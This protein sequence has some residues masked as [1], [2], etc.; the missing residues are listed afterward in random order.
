[1]RWFTD[2]FGLYEWSLRLPSILA[3]VALVPGTWF[4]ARRWNCSATNALLAA[5]LVAMDSNAIFFA[6]E[7]RVYALL[8]IVSLI[9]LFLFTELIERQNRLLVWTLWIASGIALFHLHC[10]TALI[11]GAEAVACV[12]LLATRR[13]LKTHWFY[14]LLGGCMIGLAMLPAAGLL[15][16]ISQRKDNWAGFITPTRNPFSILGV[17]PLHTYVLV[18]LAVIAV[19]F[20]VH[21]LRQ[22]FDAMDITADTA[23]QPE[24][25]QHDF[26]S[27]RLIICIAWIAVP[28][29]LAWIFTELDVARLFFRRYVIASSSALAL[30]T[31]LLLNQFVRTKRAG[32]YAAIA[33][34]VIAT[35]TIS[36]ARYA[37]YGW[38]SLSHTSEDWRTAVTAIKEDDPSIAVILYSGLIEADQWHDS[39]DEL[40]R[41]YCEFPLRGLYRLPDEQTIIPLSR[42]LPV[43]LPTK[44]TGS[45]AGDQAWLIVRA[46][47]E[48]ATKIRRQVHALLGSDWLEPV[49]AVSGNR[50]HLFR[51]RRSSATGTQA[52]PG[53]AQTP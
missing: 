49:N 23:S 39:S 3:G 30:L 47:A 12:I 24:D 45:L 41:V 19:L 10:T 29:T 35:F 46:P 53:G 37:R 34:L 1:V 27:H 26:A 4:V 28:V 51:L 36:P 5:A 50:I 38:A 7:A 40:Q 31:A 2:T 48:K 6:V 43:E 20:A 33:M 25:S 11:F 42:S 18:P 21:R 52:S 32:T 8:Q 9:H 17:F 16:E 15:R 44:S 22:R 14:L 13:E